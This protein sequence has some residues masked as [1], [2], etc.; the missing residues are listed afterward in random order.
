MCVGESAKTLIQLLTTATW[1]SKE[2]GH[3]GWLRIGKVAQI[4]INISKDPPFR[5]N[6]YPSK[7]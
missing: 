1:S 5:M 3:M 4:K 7:K 6:S 2:D